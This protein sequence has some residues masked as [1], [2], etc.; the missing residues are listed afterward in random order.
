MSVVLAGK[1][2][3]TVADLIDLAPNHPLLERT[4]LFA[5]TMRRA[6]VRDEPDMLIA[7]WTA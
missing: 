6:V 4:V 1:T 5:R 2:Y 7:R 3:I